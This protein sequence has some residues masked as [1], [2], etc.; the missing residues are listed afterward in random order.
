MDLINKMLTM[1]P[2]K[3]ITALQVLEHPWFKKAPSILGDGD[4]TC[5]A[6][7]NLKLFRVRLYLE[8]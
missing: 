7:K 4:A 3:R 1:D 8:Y 2:N 6:L 5:N